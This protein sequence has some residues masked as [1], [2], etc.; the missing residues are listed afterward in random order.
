M[1]CRRIKITAVLEDG[2]FFKAKSKVKAG[3]VITAINGQPVTKETDLS[4]LLNQC[5]GKKTLVSLKGSAGTWDEVVLPVSLSE[6][7]DLL[8]KR[9]IKSRAA[10]VERLSNGRLGYVH[11]EGMDDAS[12]RDVY[13]DILGKYNL[14]EGIVID[15]RYNG[16]GRLH[17]DIEILFSGKKYFTQVI[18]GR[19]V[20]DMPSRRYNH[21]SIM[22]QCES[23]YSNAHGTPWV[24]SHQKLGKLVGAPVPGTM[25]SVNWE[26]LQDPSLVFGVPVI[27]YQLPDGSYLENTQ[28]EPDVYI[29]NRPETVV[30]G[31]DLQLEAA[32]RELLKEL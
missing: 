20:C 3:D 5:K 15:T 18:R 9:W 19:E 13:S 8:Y 25:S 11:I 27:G 12:F 26:T 16:G 22:L 10:E 21:P 17:E 7:S 28:L 4:Q 1:T 2:P 32:V 31:T 6:E 30:K 24:Y 14:K 23:N 29:L